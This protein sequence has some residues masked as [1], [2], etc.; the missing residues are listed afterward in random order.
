M[1]SLIRTLKEISEHDCFLEIEKFMRF[2][3]RQ[4]VFR[5]Q[6]LNERAKEERD[7]A[8]RPYLNWRTIF[9]SHYNFMTTVKRIWD[10]YQPIEIELE[11]SSYIQQAALG[12]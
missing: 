6:E 3:N 12:F 11:A 5:T 8:L 7:K 9:K 1:R 4:K 2:R 10:L